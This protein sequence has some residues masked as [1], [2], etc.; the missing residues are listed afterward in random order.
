MDLLLSRRLHQLLSTHDSPFLP[1]CGISSCYTDNPIKKV[2]ANKRCF[3]KAIEFSCPLDLSYVKPLFN[4]DSA[5][6]GSNIFFF[7]F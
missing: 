5:S 7:I 1:L 6:A 2:Y 4:K 3:G